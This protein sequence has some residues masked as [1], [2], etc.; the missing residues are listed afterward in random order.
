MSRHSSSRHGCCPT[1][2]SS[3]TYICLVVRVEPCSSLLHL[4]P[5][6][7]SAPASLLLPT[8]HGRKKIPRR[9]VARGSSQYYPD[10]L[11]GGVLGLLPS[12]E[13]NPRYPEDFYA[14]LVTN[15]KLFTVQTPLSIR[16]KFCHLNYQ[17]ITVPLIT[18]IFFKQV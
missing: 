10:P 6:R 11:V 16:M 4:P 13:P 12:Q 2:T 5:R 7:A 14:S 15:N 1:Y 17:V 18:I 3:M 8:P 9:S